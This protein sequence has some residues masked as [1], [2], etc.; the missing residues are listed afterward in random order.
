MLKIVQLL[1]LIF[2]VQLIYQV[3]CISPG[4]M[5]NV[6]RP[7]PDP[8][9]SLVGS[10]RKRYFQELFDLKEKRLMAA[11]DLLLRKEQIDLEVSSLSEFYFI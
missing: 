7:K 11:Y 1:A 2:A 10:R 8:T 6:D 5:I 3:S 4:L 9:R